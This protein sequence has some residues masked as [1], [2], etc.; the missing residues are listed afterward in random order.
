LVNR[1][2]TIKLIFSKIY[3]KKIIF[4]LFIISIG[5]TLIIPNKTYSKDN[6]TEKVIKILKYNGKD[7]FRSGDPEGA[8]TIYKRIIDIN[9][10]DP[11]PYAEICVI[12]VSSR[13]YYAAIRYCT[14]AIQLAEGKYSAPFANR[15]VAKQALGDFEGAI[16][17]FSKAIK[18]DPTIAGFYSNRGVAK[19]SLKDYQGALK[20]YSK[21]IKIDPKSFVFLSLR[22]SLKMEL[23]DYKGAISDYSKSI[24]LN[25]ENYG[26]IKKNIKN[27]FVYGDLKK[28][29]LKFQAFSLISNTFTN[30]GTAKFRI[31]DYEGAIIDYSKAIEL[32]PDSAI[33]YRGRGKA[34]Q[35]LNEI[36]SACRDWGKGYEL[37]DKVSNE[38]FKS[39]C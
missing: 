29:G 6:D 1:N 12:K 21:A 33:P 39:F 35:K 5:F 16:T 31:G 27:N 38:L 15:A 24:N 11:D 34:K 17:D 37:G 36:N 23:K 7:K 3:P 2:N 28:P 20:D 26:K 22:G 10:K 14:N 18:I 32:N 19:K 25:L 13:D 4:K 30:R 9:P 8:I